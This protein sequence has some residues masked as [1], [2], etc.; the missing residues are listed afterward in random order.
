MGTNYDFL[1]TIFDTFLC[2]GKVKMVKK[3]DIY[4]EKRS[5]THLA[6]VR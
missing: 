6:I 3:V 1:T 4:L 5:N 2:S